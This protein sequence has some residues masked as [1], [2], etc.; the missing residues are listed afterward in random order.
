VPEPFVDHRVKARNTSVNSE[1]KIHDDET[2]RRYGFRGALVAG[3]IMYGY[4]TPPLVKALGTAWLERGTITVRFTKPL[5]DGEELHVT[6]AIMTRDAAGITASL[7]GATATTPECCTATATLPAGL[8]TPINMAAYRAAP[9]P[10]ERPPVSRERL[11]AL[12][13]LGTPEITYDEDTAAAFLDRLSD[14]LPIYRGS[15]GYV[16]PAFYL[17]QG[18]RAFDRNVRLGPWIHVSSTVRHLGAARMGARLETRGRVRS[19]F[20][21]KGREFA[22]LDLAILAN[23][24][25]VAHVLHTAIYSLPPP[26]A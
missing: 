22:E 15:S 4:L 8:P 26:S 7:R 9:L 21:K 13:V 14:P 12:E 1:N 23:G 20:E 19:L 11:Q 2:A 24:R 16:H 17:D 6:G 3:V 5:L 18:N 25:P 10:V